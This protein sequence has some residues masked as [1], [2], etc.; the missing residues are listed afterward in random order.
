MPTMNAPDKTRVSADYR[1]GTPSFSDLVT[2]IPG[3]V[4]DFVDNG[5]LRNYNAAETG[6]DRIM[7]LSR[8]LIP[9]WDMVYRGET[10]GDLEA[11]DALNFLP[12]GFAY[13]PGPMMVLLNRARLAKRANRPLT[14]AEL[15]EMAKVEEREM[16]KGE[17]LD[18]PSMTRRMLQNITDED[19]AVDKAMREAGLAPNSE[20][21]GTKDFLDWLEYL[22]ASGADVGAAANKIQDRIYEMSTS[23]EFKKARDAFMKRREARKS[24]AELLRENREGLIDMFDY[25]AKMEKITE[26]EDFGALLQLKKKVEA[27]GDGQLIKDFG[28][29]YERL[30][31]K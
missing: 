6:P 9:F 8:D 2:E 22:K 23:S 20:V 29:T 4:S 5:L 30:I 1:K 25:F 27:T 21:F 18:P 15:L 31:K 26:P 7:G 12:P 16:R 28:K 17:R 14:E 11:T 10:G 19:L 13:M 3:A 24:A